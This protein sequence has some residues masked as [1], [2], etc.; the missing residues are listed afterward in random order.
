MTSLKI[1]E[2]E[3]ETIFNEGH[4]GYYATKLGIKGSGIGMFI[5]KQF[6]SL[7]NGAFTVLNNVNPDNARMHMGVPYEDNLFTIAIP[8]AM[9]GYRI[10][11]QSLI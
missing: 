9:P 6:I 11:K 10:R 1:E 5:I 7:N 8:R 4:S 3:L 2:E